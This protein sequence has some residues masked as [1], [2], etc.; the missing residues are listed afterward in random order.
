MGGV[1]A[2]YAIQEIR[3]CPIVVFPLGAVD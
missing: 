2:A 3:A 1:A